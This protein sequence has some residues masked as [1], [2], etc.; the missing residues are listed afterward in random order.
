MPSKLPYL[1]QLN[2]VVSDM[3]RSLAFYRHLGVEAPKLWRGSSGQQHGSAVGGTVNGF[4]LEFDSTAFAESWNTGWT[5]RT[6]LAGRVVIGFKL[7][8]RTAVDQLYAR[9]TGDGHLGFNLPTMRS[10]ERATQ[11]SRIPMGSPLA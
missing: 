3:D 8:D 6:D 11:S 1:D 5:G 10:G 7:P 4:D 2:I 9:L